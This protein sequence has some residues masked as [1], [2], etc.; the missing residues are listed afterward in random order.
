MIIT[1]ETSTRAL[2]RI[3]THEKTLSVDAS[4]QH[5][6]IDNELLPRTP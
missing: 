1:D 4:A 5:I 6:G 2:K 3:D